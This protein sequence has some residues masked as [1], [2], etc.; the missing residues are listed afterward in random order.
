[1]QGHLLLADGLRLEGTLRGAPQTAF[2]WL[3]AN[4]SV[5]GFQEMA[6]DPAYKGTI[7][8][9]T[10]PEVGA[11]GVAERFAESA[12]VQVAAVLVK[13]LS[14]FRS[15]YLAEDDFEAMLRAAEVPCLCGVD[16]RGV[17]VHLREH[18][19][20]AAAVVSEEADLDK[21]RE[22]LKG[23][24]RPAFRASE[25]PEPPRGGSGP[26]VAVL[27]LGMRASQLK[28]LSRCCAPVAL[29]HDASPEQVTE[30]D[31]A[32]LFISD[33]PA[34]CLPPQGA[35][36]TVRS[37]AGELPIMACGLGNVALGLA[38]GCRATF[39]R[40][41]HHGA[42]CPVRNLLTDEVSVTHQRHSVVLDRQSVEESDRVELLWE[43]INDGTVEGIRAAELNATGLQDMLP[44]PCPGAV[45]PH[46]ERFVDIISD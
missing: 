39:L 29:P 23:F 7:L 11:V 20:M 41:G 4:T 16:T 28:Q 19:E 22:Q 14:E 31:P 45:S 17:A 3:V 25:L 12:S 35:V 34:T 46:I 43:N 40:R 30:T 42:N 21:V 18:G 37:L 9:F 8:G 26:R 44:G 2:G 10:Y 38:L 33:G 5:V 1:M 6:T 13:V 27:D 15:H 24:E 36:E 32:G